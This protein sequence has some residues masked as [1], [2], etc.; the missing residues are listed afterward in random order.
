LH[1]GGKLI[2]DELELKGYPDD[3]RGSYEDLLRVDLQ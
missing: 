3:S 2:P 1:E